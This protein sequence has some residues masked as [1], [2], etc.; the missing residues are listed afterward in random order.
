[1]AN[2]LVK[3]AA[4]PGSPS[5]G[6]PFFRDDLGFWCWYDGTRWLTE[7][8]IATHNSFTGSADGN[9]AYMRV[10]D[11]DSKYIEQINMT[12]RVATTNDSDNYWTVEIDGW[13]NDASTASAI[14]IFNTSADAA[15]T[16]IDKTTTS[17]SQTALPTQE[18]FFAVNITKTGSPGNIAIYYSVEY[19]EIKT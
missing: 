8:K 11:Q 3:G 17:M 4:F 19:R 1:M 7:T 16:F 14:H 10:S 12:T 5:S 15:D 2:L 13:N 6:D 9:L 18:G